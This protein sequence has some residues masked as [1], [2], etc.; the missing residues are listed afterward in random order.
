[1]LAHFSL[2]LCAGYTM[3]ES[4]NIY[5]DQKDYSRIARGLYGEE[6]YK[7]YIAIYNYLKN[8]SDSGRIKIF[9]SWTHIIE[10]LRYHDLTSEL[11]RIHC[12]VVDTLTKGNCIIF[13]AYFS[14][15]RLGFCM[16]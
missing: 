9:F 13:P 5:L 1:M 14:N 8:L 12:N 7:P 16:C 11:W 4:I 2:R 15:V 3:E 6:S 10:S